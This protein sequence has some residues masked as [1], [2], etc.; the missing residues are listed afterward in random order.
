MLTNLTAADLPD[1]LSALRNQI[2]RDIPVGFNEHKRDVYLQ[3]DAG[4]K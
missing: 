3:G 2:E 1:N 4:D